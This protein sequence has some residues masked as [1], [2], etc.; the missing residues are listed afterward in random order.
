MYIL[1]PAAMAKPERVITP[2]PSLNTTSENE[3]TSCATVMLRLLE[4]IDRPEAVCTCN[5]SS[6]EGIS[7][8]LVTSLDELREDN[9]EQKRRVYI[10]T[11]KINR[12]EGKVIAIQTEQKEVKE[13]LLKVQE[14]V[15]N[16]SELYKDLLQK[17]KT[18]LPLC[19]LKCIYSISI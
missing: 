14:N 12:T 18:V 9:A 16:V 19:K 13:M 4:R 6:I 2:L 15:R 11:Q 3:R 1:L 10:L 5:Y 17:W 7:R 8:E